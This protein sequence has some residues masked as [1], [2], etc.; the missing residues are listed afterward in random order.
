MSIY[1]SNG[2]IL[3]AR[4]ISVGWGSSFFSYGSIPGIGYTSFR[5]SLF[6]LRGSLVV[7]VLFKPPWGIYALGGCFAIFG[8]SML[9]V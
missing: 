4:K 9:V 2:N 7:L 5:W 8:V 1:L 3:G 6:F